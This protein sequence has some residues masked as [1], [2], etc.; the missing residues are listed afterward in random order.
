VVY[1]VY[2]IIR[3]NDRG[4]C[5]EIIA[6]A[7]VVSPYVAQATV[8]P[9]NVCA[10]QAL[11]KF[12][13]SVMAEV[14]AQRVVR[15]QAEF[16][17][18]DVTINF[19]RDKFFTSLDG[20]EQTPP[21]ELRVEGTLIVARWTRFEYLQSNDA[22]PEIRVFLRAMTPTETFEVTATGE[23]VYTV[24]FGTQVFM[25]SKGMAMSP[26]KAATEFVA[27]ICS[28]RAAIYGSYDG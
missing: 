9:A 28:R 12:T 5:H 20:L 27:D 15:L 4:V 11:P 22:S 18:R 16:D 26:S 2:G 21:D 10:E 3:P 1:L 19:D 25:P 6:A 7:L 8:L 14:A 23:P 17:G 13:F 24:L